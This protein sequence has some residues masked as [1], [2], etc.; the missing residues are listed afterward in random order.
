MRCK[1]VIVGQRTMETQNSA[2]AK[3]RVA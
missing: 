2:D 1:K 3:A